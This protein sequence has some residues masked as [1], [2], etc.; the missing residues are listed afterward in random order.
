MTTLLI[1]LSFKFSFTIKTKSFCKGF[2]FSISENGP[3]SLQNSLENNVDE[4]T[5]W[6]EVSF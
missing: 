2:L 4:K 3:S 6:K 1:L 5:G